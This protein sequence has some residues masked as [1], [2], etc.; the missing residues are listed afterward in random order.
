MPFAVKALDHVVLTCRNINATVKFYNLLGMKH[1]VFRS[2]KDAPGV[3]RHAL[4]FGTQKLNLHQ[5]GAEF[6]PKAIL[7]KPG[8]ADLCF[9]TSTPITD[10][11]AELQKEGLEILEGG[12][13]VDRI[14]ALGKLK[15]VYTRDPDGNL[16]EVANYV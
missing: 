8:T 11:L 15:S 9:V 3:E 16:I 2:S 1:Q 6:E 5:A 7:A 10:V 13:I 4:S 12:K 14:G